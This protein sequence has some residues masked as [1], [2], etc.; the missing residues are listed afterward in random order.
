MIP[1][2]HDN[3]LGAPKLLSRD[4]VV[5]IILKLEFEGW[6]MALR[7]DPALTNTVPEIYMNGRLFQGMVMVRNALGLSNLYLVETPGMRPSPQSATAE[8]EPDVIL[9]FAEFGANEPHAVIEC[10]RLD[11]LET[12]RS[13]RGEY[14]RSGIDRFIDGS[15]GAEHDID[16]M[17]GYLLRGD[18]HSAVT[19]I[20]TYL[21]NVGRSTCALHATQKYRTL[22]FVAESNHQRRTDMSPFR[23]L[24]SFVTFQR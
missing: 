13:L 1:L 22:G 9:L 19:D 24:H 2:G 23:L 4:D 6:Q 15:Y 16:F 3:S 10:K 12:G 5:A 8:R 21:A 18:G 20:N 7:L 17:V 14:V 11:P